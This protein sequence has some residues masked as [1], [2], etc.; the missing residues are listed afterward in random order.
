MQIFPRYIEHHLLERLQSFPVVGITGPRQAGKT[1]LATAL[2]KVLETCLVP[3]FSRAYLEG[4]SRKYEYN[5]LKNICLGQKTWEHWYEKKYPS[6][7][8]I[9]DTDWTVIRIW[10]FFRF[11]TTLWT[12]HEM[13]H[14][15]THYLLCSPD[16]PWSPD[17]LREDPENRAALFALYHQ[18]LTETQANFSILQGNTSQRL[19]EAEAIIRKIL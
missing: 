16:M 3:E 4:L 9:C 12:K 14:P 13:P 8:L 1:T 7:I 6:Q 11:G 10:E 19:K 2:A 18:L 17:P 5:D 15:N